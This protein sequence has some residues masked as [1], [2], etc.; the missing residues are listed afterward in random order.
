MTFDDFIALAGNITGKIVSAEGVTDEVI[1]PL[2]YYETDRILFIYRAFGNII[3]GTR[4]S[5]TDIETL[6][7]GVDGFFK[8]H[9]ERAIHLTQNY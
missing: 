1:H 9:L 6:E 7:G 5:M 4:V 2:S 3:Y 8:Q